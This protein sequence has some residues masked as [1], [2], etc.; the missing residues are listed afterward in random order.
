MGTAMDELKKAVEEARDGWTGCGWTTQHGLCNLDLDG[1]TAE[2]ADEAAETWRGLAEWLESLAADEPGG[3]S[4]ETLL[5]PLDAA[6]Y[7]AIRGAKAQLADTFDDENH[8][9]P[10]VAGCLADD[11]KSAAEWLHEVEDAARTAGDHGAACVAAAER[12]DWQNAYEEAEEAAALERPYGDTP[13][14]GPVRDAVRDAGVAGPVARIAE[15]ESLEDLRDALQDLD[16]VCD[17]VEARADELVDHAGLKTFGGEEPDDTALIWSWD[18]T[19]VLY[20]DDNGTWTIGSRTDD[21][22]ARAR[23]RAALDGITTDITCERGADLDAWASAF[24]TCCADVENADATAAA[25]EEAVEAARRADVD[26]LETAL[27]GAVALTAA[28]VEDRQRRE[29]AEHCAD[30]SAAVK[31]RGLRGL[32]DTLDAHACHTRPVPELPTD[33]AIGDNGDGG[34]GEGYEIVGW[35]HTHIAV[36]TWTP[37]GIT[38]HTCDVELRLI[39]GAAENY[40]AWDHAG[41]DLGEIEGPGLPEKLAALAREVNFEVGA[42]DG[43]SRCVCA[44]KRDGTWRWLRQGDTFAGF[45]SDGG[46]C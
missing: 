34:G 9:W 7:R 2:Q 19:R 20:A 46:I 6:Q 3:V 22:G 12:G 11:W 23:I 40:H 24:A 16:D 38:P 13:S 30:V 18:A 45:R 27:R 37:D 43:E 44:A 14:W 31:T 35:D 28:T 42:Y 39:P 4:A 17:E 26:A 32:S 8:G 1:V 5:N 29:W 21:G 15:A 10:W 25:A 41:N 36:V 33:W